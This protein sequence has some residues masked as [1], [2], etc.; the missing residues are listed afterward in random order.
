MTD[1]RSGRSIIWFLKLEKRN[2]FLIKE[3]LWDYYNNK[4]Q[5]ILD[6]KTKRLNPKQNGHF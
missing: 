1:T 6:Y 3:H 2:F 5:I 4:L